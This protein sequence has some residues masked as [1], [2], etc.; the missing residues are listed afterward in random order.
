MNNHDSKF[1]NGLLLGAIIGGAGVFLFGTR[2]GRNLVKI[3]S[4]QGLDGLADLL[5]EYDLFSLAEIEDEDENKEEIKVRDH[6]EEE[7]ETQGNH[8]SEEPVKE[9]PKKRFF[10]RVR[11]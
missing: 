11:R 9:S 2:T 10:K 1:L 3:V 6:H 7:L 5:E 4:E 8:V